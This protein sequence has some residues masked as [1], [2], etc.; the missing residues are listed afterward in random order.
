MNVALWIVAGLLAAMFLMAGMMKVSQP[1]EK[2]KA[3]MPWTEDF[4]PG[5]IKE[6]GVL[7]VLA[8]IGLVVPP[9]VDIAPILAP[10]AASGLALTMV[11]AAVTHARRGGEGQQIMTNLVLLA[12]LVFVAIGRFS[13]E[14]F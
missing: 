12:L 13:I 1:Y 11:G 7:E 10:V 2:L 5:V 14:P 8:A 6:I 4:S 9:L 3:S